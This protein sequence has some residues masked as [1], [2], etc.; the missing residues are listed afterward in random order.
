M[1]ST[2]EISQNKKLK[3]VYFLYFMIWNLTSSKFL[4][5]FA[6]ENVLVLNFNPGQRRKRETVTFKFPGH[7]SRAGLSH[8]AGYRHRRTR[9]GGWGGCSPPNFERNDNFRAIS[10]EV[11]GQFVG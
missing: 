9:R 10:T 6:R 5:E 4:V 1:H 2:T 11:F 7:N 8:P 3:T